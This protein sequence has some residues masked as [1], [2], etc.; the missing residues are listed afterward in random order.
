MSTKKDIGL[1]INDRKYNV[2]VDPRWTLADVI[3]DHFGQT[4]THL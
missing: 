4:G 2:S 3:R 1:T